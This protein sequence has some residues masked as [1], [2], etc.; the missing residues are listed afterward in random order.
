[1]FQHTAARRRLVHNQNLLSL[2]WLVS[3]HSRPKAAGIQARNRQPI[4]PCFNTQPPEGGWV[5]VS[6]LTFRIWRF[7][8][9]P[10]E[11]GWLHKISKM[12]RLLVFQH[13]AAR[14]RLGQQVHRKGSCHGFNTQPPEGGWATTMPPNS[15]IFCF[16]TQP[17]EGGWKCQEFY[18]RLLAVS[19]HSRPKAAGSRQAFG[20][21]LSN[22]STHSRPK[23]AGGE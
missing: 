4:F 3:T 23:A 7:N 2:F 14:R 19:T 22:V 9:Q 10:P 11:G 15:N 5:Q 20:K 6:T 8:T 21:Y 16:N 1:M 17:P 18:K 12:G 13:T